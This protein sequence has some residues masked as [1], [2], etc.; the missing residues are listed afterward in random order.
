MNQRVSG[1]GE[2]LSVVTKKKAG[3]FQEVYAN[4]ISDKICIRNFDDGYGI[5]R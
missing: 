1:V 5:M 2:S 3:Q 4:E